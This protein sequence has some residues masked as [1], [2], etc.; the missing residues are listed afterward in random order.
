[1]LTAIA[2]VSEYSFLPLTE[3]H[4][5]LYYEITILT[6]ISIDVDRYLQNVL[7]RAMFQKRCLKM[8]PLDDD[9]LEDQRE[10]GWRP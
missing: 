2:A 10:D 4:G 7:D 9:Y 3:S 1:V 6:S 5:H 8:L